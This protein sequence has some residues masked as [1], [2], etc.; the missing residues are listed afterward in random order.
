MSAMLYCSVKVQRL[1]CVYLPSGCV[2]N[3][4]SSYC[5][6]Y[7]CVAPLIGL[8]YWQWVQFSATEQLVPF[9]CALPQEVTTPKL[10]LPVYVLQV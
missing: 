3:Q 7:A 6:S 9:V 1:V 10:F 4:Y 2:P 8:Y 5:S